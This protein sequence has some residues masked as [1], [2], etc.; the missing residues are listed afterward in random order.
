MQIHGNP[1][2]Q[3][4]LKPSTYLKKVKIK[5]KKIKNQLHELGLQPP[6]HV[7][8]GNVIL[9]ESNIHGHKGANGAGQH[10]APVEDNGGGHDE[11]HIREEPGVVHVEEPTRWILVRHACAVL[12]EGVAFGAGRA[13]V[14]SVAVTAV[15]RLE[16][17]NTILNVV[18]TGV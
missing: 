3:H 2:P 12:F 7:I 18:F 6:I 4:C 13:V 17:N 15:A 16:K 1:D 11:A 8:V 5:K 14:R 10:P 9:R